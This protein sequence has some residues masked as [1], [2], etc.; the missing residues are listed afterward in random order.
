[1]YQVWNGALVWPR[2]SITK[3]ISI[4][5]L[6]KEKRIRPEEQESLE[7]NRMKILTQTENICYY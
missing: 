3:E 6:I 4:R 7:G 1:M 5:R 2:S